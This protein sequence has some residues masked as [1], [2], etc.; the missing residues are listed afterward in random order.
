MPGVEQLAALEAQ[1]LEH[2]DAAVE[3]L[4]GTVVGV[5]VLVRPPDAVCVLPRFLHTAGIIP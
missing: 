5:M 3:P 4:A 2:A 1:R